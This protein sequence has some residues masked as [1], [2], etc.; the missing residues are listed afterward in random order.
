MLFG[1]LR[2][3]N[4][5]RGSFLVLSEGQVEEENEEKF[6]DT[7]WGR[8]AKHPRFEQLSILVILL[9]GLI[10]GWDADY[11]ARFHR[12]DLEPPKRI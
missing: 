2:N 1:D 10:I 12:P 5:A 11:S 6:G 7:V 4:G 9:N 8:V 3:T